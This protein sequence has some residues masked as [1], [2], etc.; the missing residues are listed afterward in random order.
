MTTQNRALDA[1]LESL[2]RA[3]AEKAEQREARSAGARAEAPGK[4]CAT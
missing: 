3:I 2:G 1:V 4:D